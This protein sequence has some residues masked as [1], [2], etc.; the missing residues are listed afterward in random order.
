MVLLLAAALLA[1]CE[2]AE[3][4][5]YTLYRNSATAEGEP[6]RI[7]VATF[8]ACDGHDYNMANCEIARS[9]FQGKRMSPSDTGAKT[10]HIAIDAVTATRMSHWISE[11]DRHH[12]TILTGFADE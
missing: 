8:D 11:S 7:H 1:A 5:V 3:D 6:M 4:S 10:V 2:P 9:P 12:A